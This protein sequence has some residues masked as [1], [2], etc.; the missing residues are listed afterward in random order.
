M[1]KKELFKYVKICR[2]KGFSDL[3]IRDNLVKSGW[4]QKEV[5]E[6]LLARPSKR[7]PKWISWLAMA[8]LIFL[9]AAIVWSVFFMLNDLNRISDEVTT[10]IQRSHKV[11]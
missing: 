10:M 9:F 1:A 8:F 4:E 6:A 3:E 5:L 11:K 7:L 2:E